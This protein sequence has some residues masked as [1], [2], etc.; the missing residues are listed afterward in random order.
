MNLPICNWCRSQHI[1]PNLEPSKVARLG[2]FLMFIL[3]YFY[4]IE[5]GTQGLLYAC[6][7]LYHWTAF[8]PIDFKR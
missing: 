1:V 8:P 7:A 2:S 3:F 6:Q 5:R 4:G